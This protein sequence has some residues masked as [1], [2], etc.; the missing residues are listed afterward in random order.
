LQNLDLA[1][2][3]LRHGQSFWWVGTE[4]S[5]VSADVEVHQQAV[6]TLLTM[7]EIVLPIRNI[8]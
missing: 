8:V 7:S 3:L 4:I 2:V 5:H 1:G 6:Q